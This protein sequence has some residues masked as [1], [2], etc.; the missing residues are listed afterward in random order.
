[1][2]KPVKS[3][4]TWAGSDKLKLVTHCRKGSTTYS[5]AVLS[6][7]LAYRIFNLLTDAS[8]RVRLMRITYVDTDRKDRAYSTFAFVIEHKKQLA[9]RLGLKINES[10]K[11]EVRFLDARHTNLSSIY[12][13]LI[14]NTDFSRF[15]RRQVSPVAITTSCSEQSRVKSCPYLMISTCPVL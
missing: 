3:R 4:S 6:E 11:S 10:P 5:Q 15:A 7:H 13:Y 9:K 1:M 12:Q 8:F 2:L 14:G